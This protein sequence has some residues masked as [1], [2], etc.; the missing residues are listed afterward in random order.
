[1][2][3]QKNSPQH[4]IISYLARNPRVT[5]KVI[6]RELNRKLGKY[7]IQGVYRLLR[8]LESQGVILHQGKHYQLRKTWA[9]EV[10]ALYEQL[11]ENYF[12]SPTIHELYSG[13]KR[14][15]TW[16]FSDLKKTD[17]FWIQ[18]M[19]ELLRHKESNEMFL[20]MSHPWFYLLNYKEDIRFQQVLKQSNWR[21]LMV[22]GN[23]TFL[24]RSFV[25][26]WDPEVY[27]C[28]FAPFDM[29]LVESCYYTVIGD[30]LL[31]IDIGETLVGKLDDLFFETKTLSSTLPGKVF[32]IASQRWDIR[33][34]LRR[35]PTASKRLLKAFR[36]H[37]SV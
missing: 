27:K 9:Y 4:V 7:T 3:P 13:E 10:Q 24:S 18:L 17:G 19:L 12:S 22:F 21:L 26:Y 16:R 25:E 30:Y 8:S 36:E 29:E 6:E 5:A 31:E 23:D 2:L 11:E 1:M 37:F 35:S 14:Q 20:W 28:S 34:K 15:L 33:V 32:E